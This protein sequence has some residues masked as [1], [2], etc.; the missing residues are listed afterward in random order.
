MIPTTRMPAN[1][2]R[3]SE[4]G[5]FQSPLA[6]AID[7]PPFAGYKSA[8]LPYFNN[9]DKQLRTMM[10]DAVAL[11]EYLRDYIWSI[12]ITQMRAAAPNEGPAMAAPHPP[13]PPG[14][15]A[16]ETGAAGGGRGA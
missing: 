7:T 12:G 10:G 8:L 15:A 16:L 5:G 11:T 14:M 2:P 9:D 13:L 6:L 3:N 4:T 1:F